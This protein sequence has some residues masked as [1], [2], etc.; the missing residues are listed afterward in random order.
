MTETVAQ[1]C[2][3]KKVFLEILQNSQENTCQSLFLNKVEKQP[4]GG[5]P[6]N[7]CSYFPG[8]IQIDMNT[9]ILLEQVNFPGGKCYLEKL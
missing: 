8:Y 7:R 3:V 1:R 2:S 9:L 4:L 6:K 5:V